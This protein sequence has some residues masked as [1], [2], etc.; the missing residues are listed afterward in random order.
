VLACDY[1]TAHE[2]AQKEA[3]QGRTA[4]AAAVVVVVVHA[5]RFD[6]RVA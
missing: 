4:T 2:C 1:C 3:L 6:K 5:G